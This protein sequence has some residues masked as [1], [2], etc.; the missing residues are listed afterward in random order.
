MFLSPSKVRMFV[1]EPQI[2]EQALWDILNQAPEGITEFDLIK[3]LQE[4][5][6]CCLADVDLVQ[7]LGLFQTHF[8]L[9][10]FL[11]RMR[12]HWFELEKGVLEIISTRIR[13]RSYQ[14]GQL[15]L[16][17]DDPL[18][19]YYLDWTNYTATSQEDVEQML[20]QFWQDFDRY[21]S[22]G[23]LMSGA[24]YAEACATLDLTGPFTALELK[25]QYRKLMHQHHPD[26][27]G[28]LS[29]SQAIE[30]AYRKLKASL[31]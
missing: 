10:H 6:Y 1:K 27:G 9:F 29:V 13:L 28:D 8:S 25:Q 24:E 14:P 16:Q 2:C 26:K 19:E 11:Y 4:A 5:P 17:L 18:A 31:I 23:A 12:N 22:A 3:Q 7:P 20:D 15:I 21:Y 30:H